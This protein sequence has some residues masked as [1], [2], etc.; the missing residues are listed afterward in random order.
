VEKVDASLQGPVPSLNVEKQVVAIY[1]QHSA[2][3]LRYATSLAHDEEV[4]Q[5]SV[6]EVFLRFFIECRAGREIEHP[7]AWLYQALRNHLFNRFKSAANQ[8]ETADGNL[9][10]FPDH[11]AHPDRQFRGNEIAREIAAVLTPRELD[12]FLLRAE[13]FGYSEIAEL[14]G[15]RPGTVGSLLSRVS[16]KLRKPVREA[17]PVKPA[18]RQVPSVLSLPTSV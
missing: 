2:D 16:R 8:L 5:D 11:R 3:L 14:M 7:R 17:L 4:A 9:E 10:A 13:G 15:V 18:P 1:E 6:Q 12:C